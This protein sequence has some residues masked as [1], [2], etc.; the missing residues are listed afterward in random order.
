MINIWRRKL[1]LDEKY[2]VVYFLLEVSIFST[3]YKRQVT[4]VK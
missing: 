1:H 3:R 2:N 4:K